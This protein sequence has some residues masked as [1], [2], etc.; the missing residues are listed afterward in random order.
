MGVQPSIRQI[1]KYTVLDV[2]G[3]GGMGIVYR[4]QDPAI[5]RTV[6]IKMLK[7][8]DA[9]NTQ[10]VFDRFFL[11]EMKS[12]GNLHH[13]N[14]VTVYDAGE[15]EGNPYLVMEYLEGEPVSKLISER[16]PM[17]LLDKLDLGIQVCDGLQ[18]AHDRNVIH[19]DI[20]PANVILL[21]DRTVKIVD[22]GV[23]RVAGSETSLAQTGQLVGSLSYMSPEQINSL[24]L[25]GRS[26]I[27]STG[28]MLFELLTGEVPFR[29]SDPSST[30]VKILREEAAPLSKF[31][32][33]VPP[34]LQAVMNRALAKNAQERYQ[35]AEE[36]G[37]DLL[38]LQ[39]DLKA[40]T[41]ADCLKRAEAAM[42]RGDL[43]RGRVLLQDVIRLDRH[44]EKA[45]R[46]LRELRAQT[47][48]QQR[49]GQ[50]IQI[51]SQAQVALAGGQY[52]EALACADQALRL[53]P[54]D[55]ESIK[56]CD[57]IRN[58]IARAK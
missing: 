26:D 41:A 52:E 47:Q 20:K 6:A 7:N 51:R 44:N 48:T 56:L 54:D 33:D 35:S 9:G 37:F 53:N 19:R 40:S 10:D 13:K 12:T 58:A 17:P 30:F 5:G 15:H 49:S 46:L 36:F 43:D 29:G 32:P 24:P 57:Q 4:A 2:I 22:F 45:N 8:R 38:G 55:T 28:V 27:F 21:A 42:Q 25:D 3:T 18:Y 39:K 50:V 31:L 16:R 34:A 1:G 23:A 11:R 14:I